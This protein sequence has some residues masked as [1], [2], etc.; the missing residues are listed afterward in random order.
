MHDGLFTLSRNAAC[1]PLV[2]VPRLACFFP[3]AG[4]LIGSMRVYNTQDYCEVLNEL[5]RCSP[6]ADFHYS[7]TNTLLYNLAMQPFRPIQII[8]ALAVLATSVVTAPVP[9]S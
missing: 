3:T 7:S 6:S 4:G 9:Q 8:V 1:Y 5:L 2:M